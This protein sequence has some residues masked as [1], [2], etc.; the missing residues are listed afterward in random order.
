MSPYLPS[1]LLG[2]ACVATTISGFIFEGQVRRA[3]TAIG[4]PRADTYGD[5]DNYR[6][7]VEHYPQHINLL[8]LQTVSCYVLS[9]LLLVASLVSA[10]YA[11]LPIAK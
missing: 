11:G 6:C 7:Y 8:N 2:G 4:D 10:H 1:M 5:E 9:I 3:L